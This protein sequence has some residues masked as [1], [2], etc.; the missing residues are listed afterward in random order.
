MSPRAGRRRSGRLGVLG[1]GFEVSREGVER[2]GLN[3]IAAP[4]ALFLGVAGFFLL[5]MRQ[6]LTVPGTFGYSLAQTLFMGGALLW[7]ATVLTGHTRLVRDWAV[8]AAVLGYV[9]A[10]FISYAAAAARGI[11]PISQSAVDRY[12]LTDLMLAGTVLL[13]LTV[14][15]TQHALRVMLGGLVLGGT[16]SALFAL[17]DSSTGIDIAAQFRIPGLTKG[18]DYVLI[19]SLDRAGVTR[20]QG[21]AG[22]PLELGAVLTVLAPLALALYFNAKR[23]AADPRVVRLWLA[24]TV[25]ILTADLATVSRSAVAGGLAAIAVMCWRWPVQRL[26]A[27]LGT[28]TA[29]VV[30]GVVGQLTLVTALIETFAGSSKDPSLQSREVGRNFVAEN[31]ADNFWLGQGVGAYPT[32]KQPV[33]D[34]Q[35][36]SR[37]MEAGIFGLLSLCMALV[38]TLYLAVRASQSKDDAL[39]ELAGGI[40]GSAAALIVIC[41]ILDTSGFGQIWYLTWILLALAGVVY[42]LSRVREGEL[43]AP[44]P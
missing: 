9:C 32:L 18:S 2:L 29:V 14:L 21:S 22:H 6:V 8:I 26:A 4:G 20:P 12:V 3:R 11:L 44:P 35:Y 33:L 5:S 10:S 41:L 16:V 34:N 30:V 27:I 43:A 36:L 42:R 15:R 28:A 39:A 31:L 13:T 25:I 19:E 23:R 1:R 38:V 40:S 24:C 7:F 17:L 37:L